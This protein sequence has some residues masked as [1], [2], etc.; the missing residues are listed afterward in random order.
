MP[1]NR[2]T[3]LSTPLH[4]LRR[5]R[6]EAGRTARGRQPGAPFIG[7]PLT[8]LAEEIIDGLNYC[9]E[10]RQQAAFRSSRHHIDTISRMLEATWT[11]L[12]AVVRAEGGE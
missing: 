1:I 4:D 12:L 3:I 5:A 9:D 11:Y 6:G 7:D 10:A 8:E 2:R